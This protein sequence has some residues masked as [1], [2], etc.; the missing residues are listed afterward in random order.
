MT[1][2]NANNAGAAKAEWNAP[3]LVT[4]DANL[5]DIEN[6][7]NPVSDSVGIGASSAS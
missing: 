1:K 5:A 4:I 6:S 2:K 3:Q 7:F